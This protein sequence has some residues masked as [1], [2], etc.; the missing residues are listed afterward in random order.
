[1]FYV[2]MNSVDFLSHKE[3]PRYND[4][5]LSNRPKH[6]YMNS[7][8]VKQ[9]IHERK[10]DEFFRTDTQAPHKRT[11]VLAVLGSVSAVLAST[12]YFAKKQNPSLNLNSIK[13][14]FKAANFH[15]GQ[16]EVFTIST[17]GVLGGLAGGLFDRKEK[18][19]LKKIEEATFQ[20]TNVALTSTLVNQSA[21]LCEKVKV[22]NNPVAKIASSILGIGVGAYTAVAISNK[23]DDKFFDKYNHDPER[24][25]KHKD[26]VVH[27]DDFLGALILAKIPFVDK[28]NRVLPLIYTWSGYH[29][30]E[31]Q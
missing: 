10:I 2:S 11:S 29:V 9:K 21:K 12:L 30:G 25:L 1:M 8:Y 24:I 26:F 28:L 27:L 23:L 22:L 19:K 18:H 17:A 7:S 13:N 6:H 31:A 3:D 16:R 14:I 5:D 15:Y 4:V 20:I